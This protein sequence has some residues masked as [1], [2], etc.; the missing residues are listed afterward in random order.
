MKLNAPKK[1]VW[2]IALIVGL[3]GIILTIFSLVPG[4]SFVLVAVAWLLLILATYLKG[5]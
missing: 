4:L 5:L 1:I 3:L 2:L